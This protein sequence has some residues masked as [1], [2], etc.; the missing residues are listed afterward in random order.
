MEKLIDA[1]T[2]RTWLGI[3][4]STL[5]RWEEE[6]IIPKPING[7]GRKRLWTASTIERWLQDRQQSVTPTATTSKQR[8]KDKKAFEQRQADAQAALDRHSRNR[9]EGGA[10]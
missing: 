6:E 10:Q 7:K 2:L 1:K 3:H 4:D 5:T 9:K 8:K